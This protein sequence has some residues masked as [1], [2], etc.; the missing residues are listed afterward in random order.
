MTTDGLRARI[1]GVGLW[2]PGYNDAAA[3][4]TGEPDFEAQKPKAKVLDRQCS[5]RAS[6]FGKTLALVFDEAAT[7]AQVDVTQVAAVFGSAL[8]ETEVMLKLLDQ[9]RLGQD[10]FSPMLF[11]VSVHN[12]ASGLVSIS[13]KNRAFTT[14]VAADYDTPAMSLME[15]IGASRDLGVPAVL[16]CGDDASPPGLVPEPQAYETLAAAVVVD[17]SAV[18]VDRPALAELRGFE[19]GSKGAVDEQI[20]PRLARNPQ[21][22]LLE[23]INA[24]VRRRFGRITLDRGEGSRWSV[25]VVEAP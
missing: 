13:T 9:M 5:R 23:V 15:A 17:A 2:T 20:G 11:A 19:M 18:A 14:S 12:A 7:Q 8:G 4:A 16:V 22:G 24:V 6:P 1:T 21:I 3:W 10:D 25:E